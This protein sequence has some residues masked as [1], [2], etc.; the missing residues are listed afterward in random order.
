MER[1]RGVLYVV[2]TPIGNLADISE[3]ARNTLNAVDLI[4]AEDTRES[5]RLLAHLG[6]SA[7]LVSCHEHNAEGC[8]ARVLEALGEGR[9]V[10]LVS[11]AGTPLVSDPGYELV[12]AARAA[13]FT[14]VP[15]PGP[16]ALICALS[17]AGLPS[18]RFLFLGFPPR[19]QSQ[20]V[21]LFES[22][23]A[24]PGTLIL[25]ESGKRAV[26]TLRDLA[27]VL[28]ERRAVVGR[29]L[30]KRFETFLS[31][32]PAALAE[33]LEDDAEQRLG[34][35]VILVEGQR[36]EAAP[37]RAEQ[38][39]VLRILAEALPLRRAAA[40]AAQITGAKTNALYRLG[41]ELELGGKG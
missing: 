4:A 21:A 26:A 24:E 13:D 12:N 17:A 41:V 7:R 37:D 38:E 11:D 18:D 33:R 5:G 16:S 31:A 2:A 30:T 6:I 1:G 10:A 35:L 40:L 27:A 23:L 34:E 22:L 28:G 3:R 19:G 32:T 25:Y 20:R 15:V 39:R 9:D 14:V 36:G 8:C 29:E